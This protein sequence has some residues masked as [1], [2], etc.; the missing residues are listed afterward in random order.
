MNP[1][2]LEL[3]AYEVMGQ[4]Q[5]EIKSRE[6]PGSAMEDLGPISLVQTTVQG[7]ADTDRRS[8]LQ[9]ALIAALEAL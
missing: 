2:Y 7:P 4:I 6:L 1:F 3:R 5:I 9:D 8:W